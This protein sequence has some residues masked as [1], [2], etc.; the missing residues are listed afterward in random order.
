MWKA[1]A[2]AMLAVVPVCVQGSVCPV[3]MVSGT[4]DA[5]GIVLTFRNSGKLLIRQLEFSCT[6]AQVRD[7]GRGVCRERN[8][9]FYPGMQYTVRY[10]YPGGARGV[11]TVV[12]KSVTTADG[13]VWKPS[14][15]QKCRALRITPSRGGASAQRSR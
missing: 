4:G 2:L 15:K 1:I 6:T 14:K 3:M 10:L 13:F 12:V 8:A 7:S 9:L 5:D 11:V